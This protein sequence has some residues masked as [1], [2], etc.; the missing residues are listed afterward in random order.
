[1]LTHGGVLCIL[2]SLFLACCAFPETYS[3]QRTKSNL[4]NAANV[5]KLDRREIHDGSCVSGCEGEYWV[6]VCNEPTP[7]M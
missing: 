2:C 1:M 7:I 5:I 6:T 4:C 3:E